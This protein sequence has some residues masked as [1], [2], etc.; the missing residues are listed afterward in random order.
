ME[1]LLADL[2]ASGCTMHA[3]SNYPVWYELVEQRLGLSRFLEWTFVSCRTGLRKPDPAAYRSVVEEL[4]IPAE[5][6][7]FVDDRESNCEAARQSGMGS[8]KFE[9]ADSLRAYL[10]ETEVL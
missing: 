5:H 8:V 7:V 9:G 4:G 1:E 10:A 2:R 6:F 3:F